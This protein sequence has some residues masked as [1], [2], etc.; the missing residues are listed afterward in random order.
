MP[1]IMSRHW[2]DTTPD[3]Q[4]LKDVTAEMAKTSADI[5]KLAA[6]PKDNEDVVRL[7]L[8]TEWFSREY[9]HNPVVT[10]SMSGLGLISR[11]S[12]EVSGSAI[13]FASAGK[14]SA[15]GQIDFKEMKDMLG[16]VHQGML[17]N[18]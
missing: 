14:A 16:K 4:T 2:F 11:I 17:E 18:K 9:P 12:G 13:T 1:V 15:P 8:M 7:L 3:D 10:V 6:M 5:F